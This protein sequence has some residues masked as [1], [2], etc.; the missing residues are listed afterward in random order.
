MFTGRQGYPP[1]ISS[2]SLNLIIVAIGVI[3]AAMLAGAVIRVFNNFIAARNACRNARSGI[4]VQLTKRH[5]L[6]PNLE[7]AVAAYAEHERE[8]LRLVMDARNGAMA[9]LGAPT[10][11]AAE[12]RLEQALTALSVRLEAYPDLKAS[13]NFLHLQK[14]LTEIEEQLSAARRSFNAHV[15]V[16]NNLAG[17]FPTLIVARFFGF[18]PL[19]FYEAAAG[20]RGSGRV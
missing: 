7:R 19:D 18:Q 13:S 6:V 9:K 20:E 12:A 5:D 14:A 10:S 17:Q 15:V 11:A 8:A 2:M 1:A 16:L 4:D 3:V